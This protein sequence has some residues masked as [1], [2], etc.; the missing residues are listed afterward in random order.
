MA[1]LHVS[2][3]HVGQRSAGHTVLLA[4]LPAE[5]WGLSLPVL[6]TGVVALS[7]FTALCGC[8]AVRTVLWP[9]FALGVV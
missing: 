3:V 7:L 6:S 8:C 2:L 9:S 4:A 5:L 1:S